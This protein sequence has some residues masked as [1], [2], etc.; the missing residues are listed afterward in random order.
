MAR[1]RFMAKDA[2]TKEE[3]M[4]VGLIS[5]L[6]KVTIAFVRKHN[7]GNLTQEMFLILRDVT[8]A[9]MGSMLFDLVSSLAHKEQV[10]LFLDEC[11][12]IFE[13]YIEDIKK[14]YAVHH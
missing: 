11:K 6:D 13:C 3:K 2:K 5:E 14:R 10:D 1:L 8:L 4:I 9:Y 7:A 12:E